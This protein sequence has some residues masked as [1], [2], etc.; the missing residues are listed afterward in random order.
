MKNPRILAA[1]MITSFM[2]TFMSSAL[3]LSVPALESYFHVSAAAISWIVSSYTISV[4]AMS[5]PF[6]K[7]ADITGRRKIF[8]T[9]IAGFGILSVI[10]IF[11]PGIALLITFRALM[12]CCGA[13]IFATNN[14]ILISSYPP[15]MRGKVL[16][17]S[18]AATYIGLTAGPVAGGILNSTLG[19]R[20]IF[21]L[22]AVISAAAFGAAFRTPS[23]DA[24]ASHGKPEKLDIT[25]AVLYIAAITSSLYGLTNLDE[26]AVSVLILAAGTA[27][28][29][30]FFLHESGWEKR[31]SDPVMNVSMFRNS[32]TFTFSN[33]AA[34]L[35][36]ASTFA[37][38][39]TMS[40][41]LQVILG[42]PSA[43]AGL[44]L[45]TMPAVQ[46]LFSPLT[47][48]LS[49]RVRPS[50]LASSGMG[51]CAATLIMFSRLS[52]HTSLVYIITALCITGFGF[53]LFSSP[54]TNAILSCVSREDYGV[55]N[56]IIATM[57]T[58]G[59]SSGMAIVSVITSLYL[60]SNSL[61]ASPA[62]DILAMMHTAFLVFA[63]LCI[64]GLFF[65]LARDK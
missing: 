59:Q 1:A 49:D 2:T 55:A 34:L 44:L 42:I 28:L 10:S 25:G 23:A 65:S 47:G 7:I 27:A 62:S 9:G 61:E 45:I 31:G 4:A 46:A 20:S 22:S 13:M 32:R 60:G 58:F 36:Y 24:D 64:A 50:V 8:L 33:L 16:G 26:G 15:E 35:N 19:W 41:Y 11:A 48:S 53:A 5:L 18:V 12:G 37:I 14:A 29:I 38:S 21:A 6:G 54:N 30:I 17:Y 40:I 43:R 39:Y 51:L 63:G 3:N 57:R 56:S 52:G